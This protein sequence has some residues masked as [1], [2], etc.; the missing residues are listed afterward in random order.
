MPTEKQKFVNEEIRPLC[1][2][3]RSFKIM[4]DSMT[5][6]WYA[7]KNSLFENNATPFDDGRPD[8]GLTPMTEAD[9]HSAVG[10]LIALVDTVNDT[11]LKYNDQI[12]E[13][14]TVNPPR[15]M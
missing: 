4:V 15:V 12:M 14:P 2:L 8:E 5:A 7:G 6:S 1:E 11:R 9:I 10:I 13:K 3:A